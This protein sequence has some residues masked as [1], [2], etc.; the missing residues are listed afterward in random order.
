MKYSKAAALIFCGLFIGWFA[1]LSVQTH[2][3]STPTLLTQLHQQRP[4]GYWESKEVAVQVIHFY[5]EPFIS[6]D[7]KITMEESWEMGTGDVVDTNGFVV[8]NKHVVMLPISKAVA[9]TIIQLA[10][11]LPAPPPDRYKVCALLLEFRLCSEAKVMAVD[12]NTDIALVKA[13]QYF[14]KAISFVDDHTLWPGDEIYYWGNIAWYLPPSPVEGKYF[15]RVGPPYY[16]EEK[17]FGFPLPLLILDSTVIPG[18]SGAAVY[19]R[20]GQ[21][22]GMVTAL[23]PSVKGERVPGIIIPSSTVIEFLKKNLPTQAP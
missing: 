17:F 7:G 8:T 5:Y 10:N 18:S 11:N 4:V 2:M 9:I 16:T 12:A 1:A 23:P 19:N 15:G 22:V 20:L 3:N 6:D 21:A 13:D 14:A